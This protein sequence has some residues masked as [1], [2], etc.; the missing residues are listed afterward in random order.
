MA[1]C[2]DC[3]AE[4]CDCAELEALAEAAHADGLAARWEREDLHGLDEW[5][6]WYQPPVEAEGEDDA[7]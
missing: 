7:E 4:A 6:P 3:G 2:S 5:D 1:P